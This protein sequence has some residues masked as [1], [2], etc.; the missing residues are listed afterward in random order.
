MLNA[1]FDGARC[2]FEVGL[3]WAVLADELHSGFINFKSVLNLRT[4][5]DRTNELAFIQL[6]TNVFHRYFVATPSFIL[7]ET[8]GSSWD[9]TG[10]HAAPR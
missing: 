4:G 10:F 5:K 1:W 3:F 8:H 9:G 2:T 7:A 6:G